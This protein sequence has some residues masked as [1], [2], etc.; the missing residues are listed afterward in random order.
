M[1]R[2]RARSGAAVATGGDDGAEPDDAPPAKEP[3]ASGARG[4]RAAARLTRRHSRHAL[5]AGVGAEVDE[6]RG[7]ASESG[8]GDSDSSGAVLGDLAAK[9]GRGHR[10]V[11]GHVKG[12][13][14]LADNSRERIREHLATHG[15][16]LVPPRAEQRDK[17][18]RTRGDAHAAASRC[19]KYDG[20]AG[21]KLKT[22][23][24][25]GM[26]RQVRL[27]VV[28]DGCGERASLCDRRET[29]C[30]GGVRR[31]VTHRLVD[32]GDP[33]PTGLG[34]S[35]DRVRAA[36]L[37]KAVNFVYPA[38]TYSAVEL[39]VLRSASGTG[40]QVAHADS[41]PG[42]IKRAV[43]LQGGLEKFAKNGYYGQPLQAI[44]PLCGQM[45]CVRCLPVP[46][47]WCCA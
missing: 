4:P 2:K 39:N 7:S 30:A 5:E 23:E 42:A 22:G 37:D 34:G 12:G 45:R 32:D 13:K 21:G 6:E 40:V 36:T 10:R 1:P 8:D 20:P 25:D 18:G 29:A 15:W 19:V 38:G 47:C 28:C 16:G 9:A 3:C 17:K 11:K 35:M 31:P 26:R 44:P 41:P 24:G 33:E 14:A 27:E 46:G 43:G